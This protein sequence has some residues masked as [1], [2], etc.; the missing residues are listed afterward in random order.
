MSTPCGA[1][2]SNGEALSR[3]SIVARCTP[4]LEQFLE[5][6]GGFM[7]AYLRQHSERLFK[8]TPHEYR[9]CLQRSRGSPP[10]SGCKLDVAGHVA[11]R[12]WGE[13]HS[14][15]EAPDDL[16]ECGLVPRAQIQSLYARGQRSSWF[17]T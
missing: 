17:S 11:C 13:D 6:F 2:S 10:T 4:E 12:Y 8:G 9:P 7:E 14:C 15:I 1:S 3:K 16:R 5:R